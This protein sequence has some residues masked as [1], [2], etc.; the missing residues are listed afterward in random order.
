[1][2]CVGIRVGVAGGGGELRVHHPVTGGEDRPATGGQTHHP[3][4]NRQK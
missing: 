4:T 1:M 3:V 2:T